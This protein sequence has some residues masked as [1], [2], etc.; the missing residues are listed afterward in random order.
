MARGLDRLSV[1]RV[2]TAGPGL[3]ADGGG[4]Y[5]QVG[6]TGSR[7]WIFRYAIGGRERA[8]G[9][10]PLNAVGLKQ[11]REK[12]KACRAQRADG[13]D[14]I[15]AR[16]AVRV[17][18]ATVAT[19]ESVARDYLALHG[20]TLCAKHRLQWEAHLTQYVLPLIGALPVTAI[21]VDVV[22]KVLSPLW[23]TKADTASRLRGRIEAILG[24]ATVRGLRTG[25]NPA[26]WRG[27]LEHLLPKKSRV[28]R[29]AHH[30]AMPYAELPAF[31]V[32]LRAR[33]GAAARALE[34]LILTASRTS[35]VLGARWNEIDTAA[36]LWT[37]PA[38]RMKGRRPHRVPL[39][40]PALAV[41]AA[42]PRTSEF[43]FT[44]ERRAGRPIHHNGLAETMERMGA[45]VTVHGFRSSFRDWAAETTGFPNEVV[46]MALAHTIRNSAEAAYRRGDL[47]DKR[48]DLMSA[49][50]TF[51]RGG[52]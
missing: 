27:N 5:L 22:F 23:P 13:L 10:G 21:D 36:A 33:D 15:E 12:A 50:G 11:A 18:S 34:L 28:H 37:V 19:F 30:K 52:G 26:T 31:L 8:M 41:L 44:A 17:S 29:V 24:A 9:L 35:E 16:A 40:G 38:E 20:P 42:L 39:S 48:R 14:P 51:C 6:P 4:L 1:R 45:T 7:S 43:V 32:A 3:H 25:P 47:L 2:E 46:E 49:W